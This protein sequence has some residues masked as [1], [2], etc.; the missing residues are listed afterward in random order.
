MDGFPTTHRSARLTLNGP[1][2]T[3]RACGAALDLVELKADIDSSFV[4]PDHFEGSAEGQHYAPGIEHQR[5]YEPRQLLQPEVATIDPSMLSHSVDILMDAFEW[6]SA[7]DSPAEGKPVQTFDA[8]PCAV[9]PALA[10]SVGPVESEVGAATLIET[11]ESASSSAAPGERS[12]SRTS[13]VSPC[14]A[15]ATFTPSVVPA[16]PGS[17]VAGS[18]SPRRQQ[19]RIKIE[20]AEGAPIRPRRRYKAP[21][22]C[23]FEGCTELFTT[24]YDRRR[25]CT[26]VHGQVEYVYKCEQVGCGY[27]RPRKDKVRDHCPKMNHV[28]YVEICVKDGQNPVELEAMLNQ[29]RRKRRRRSV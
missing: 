17:S 10:P 24:S 14:A 20:R 26:D 12:I 19:H 15:G 9:E 7:S 8:S 16:G 5:T 1:K 27:R 22:Q 2:Q 13:E 11:F 23:Y 28:R 21:Q 3:G 6:E 29:R 25:H 18:H 4:W